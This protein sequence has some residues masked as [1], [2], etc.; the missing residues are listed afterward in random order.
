MDPLQLLPG[1]FLPY[2]KS[3]FLS[4][5]V[6]KPQEEQPDTLCDPAVG[7]R[8]ISRG[9]PSPA[10]TRGSFRCWPVGSALPSWKVAFETSG[11]SLK[12]SPGKVPFP[13]RDARSALHKAPGGRGAGTGTMGSWLVNHWVSAAVLV[14]VRGWGRQARGLGG[15]S[16]EMGTDELSWAGLWG[17]TGIPS[18]RQPAHAG[19]QGRDGLWKTEVLGKTQL[20]GKGV[21]ENLKMLL[22]CLATLAG[23]LPRASSPLVRGGGSCEKSWQGEELAP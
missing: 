1:T 9:G 22:L 7:P 13:G 16:G 10:S 6:A 14:S 3:P 18:A 19:G 4:S 8:G 11:I 15:L 23:S 5:E 2:K 12:S 21:L 17:E 20:T